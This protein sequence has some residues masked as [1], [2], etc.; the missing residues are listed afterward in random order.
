VPDKDSTPDG[1]PSWE[2]IDILDIGE[3]WDIIDDAIEE[4]CKA[5]DA[6]RRRAA[7]RRKGAP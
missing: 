4:R 7:E 1:R 2:Q 3:L 5:E 6:K